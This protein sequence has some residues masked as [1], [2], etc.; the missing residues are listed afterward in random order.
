M[1]K[2]YIAWFEDVDKH[3]VGLVGG[4]GANLGEMTRAHFPIPYGFVVTSHAYFHFI[5]EANLAERISQIVSIINFEHTTELEQASEHIKDLIMKADVPTVLTDQILEYYQDL[6]AKEEE[7]MTQ[8]YSFLKHT[9]NKL[10]SV[11]TQP[12]V[13][14]RSSA[15]A[16]DLPD[17]SFAG[18]QETFLNVRGEHALLRKVKEC[19]ASL[20][21]PRAIYYRHEQGFDHFKVGLAAVVQRMV[22]SDKS[23]IAFSIDPVTND[24]TK[25]VIEA[26]YGLGEYIVQGK[27]TPDHYEI[28]KNSIVLTKKQ[29]AYQNVKYI[30]SGTSNREVKLNKKDGA[31]Q[32]LSDN[33][34]RAV[35]L[36]VKEVEKHYFFPQDIE[37]A[38]EHGQVYIVQS[39]PI[40]TIDAT[41][42]KIEDQGVTHTHLEPVVTGAPASPGIGVGHVRI[43]KSPKEIHKVEQGDILVAPQTNPD[44]VPAMK[45]AAAIVTD[46]GG[47]TSHAAIVSRELGIPAVVGTE[48]A[49][50][51]LKDGELVSVDGTNGNVYRGSIIRKEDLKAQKKEAAKKQPQLKTLTKVYANLAEPEIAAKVAAQG[52][53]GIGLLRAE[54]MIAEIGIHPKE[55]IKQKKEA[56]FVNKLTKNLETFVKAFD[57][58]PVVYRA[59]DFKSN[60]YRHLKGGALYE[61]HEENPMIG[62]RGA[63]RYIANPDVFA[64]ELAAIRN[65]WEKGY[66]NLHLMIPFIR[67][68]WELIRIKDIVRENGLFN[69]KEFKFWIMVEVPAAAIMLQEFIDIGIDGVSIGTNDL[70]MMLL[71]VDRDSSEVSHIY[72]ERHPA[73]T[74]VLDH[75]VETCAAAGITC[76]ICGQAASD[77]PEIV[78]RLVRK[79]ITSVSVAPDAVN[80]TRSLIHSIEKKVHNSK[81]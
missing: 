15:T 61:P 24:K 65:I 26:V 2:K 75:I 78:E 47:R 27:V 52:V 81:L 68:P 17:A 36:Q 43:I 50:K 14:V 66:K 71:G 40:T 62:Y 67:V 64:L 16:E 49:T 37:W 55:F 73:V 63:S 51:K 4:K 8:K 34:I 1:A 72:D 54:F 70:T 60:E 6:N 76:S 48:T 13:A 39:R 25:I 79:G 53:D 32:K 7:Y 18:Q 57:G 3:D 41:N 38:M 33:E 20:F 22:Q 10:K 46:K 59:T 23:G 42:K 44:Y 74:S 28:D 35:A 19:W 29:T 21:T 45:K 12:L 69:H 11:Y 30:K 5:K 9:V 77:Y 58:K 80:R 31:M 56:I